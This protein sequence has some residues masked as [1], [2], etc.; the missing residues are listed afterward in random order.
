MRWP[1]RRRP[2][3]VP[4]APTDARAALYRSQRRLDEAQVYADKA[5]RLAEQVRRALG[6]R[7]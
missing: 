6:L 4:N 1:W 5:D 2:P 3:E 7:P